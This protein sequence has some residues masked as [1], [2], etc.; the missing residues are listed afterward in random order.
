MHAH[1]YE[2]GLLKVLSDTQCHNKWIEH[3]DFSRTVC[4]IEKKLTVLHALKV[5]AH[6]HEGC[7]K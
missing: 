5:G 2:G 3:I 6:C 1:M 7:V 4:L